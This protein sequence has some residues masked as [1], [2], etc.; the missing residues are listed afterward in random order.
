MTYRFLASGIALVS[1]CA[2]ANLSAPSPDAIARLPVVTFPETPPAGDFVFRIPAGKP[3]PTHV[4]VAGSAL[5]SGA[6]KTLEVTLPHDIYVHK[7]W[8]SDDGRQWR[9]L[10]EVLAINLSL[11]LPSDEH[12]KPGEL[13]LTIDRKAPQ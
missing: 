11:S 1:L 9:P 13:R 2:C 4:A 7:R 6:E 8:I 5:A 3:I 12:P 10:D